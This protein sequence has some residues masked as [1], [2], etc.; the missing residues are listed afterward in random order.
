M[1]GVEGREDQNGAIP[2]GI[3]ANFSLRGVGCWPPN[4]AVNASDRA[5]RSVGLPLG[6][7]QSDVTLNV[8]SQSMQQG[9]TTRL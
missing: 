1:R 4:E 3:E 6:V 2:L 5:L 7:F 8:V 9:D